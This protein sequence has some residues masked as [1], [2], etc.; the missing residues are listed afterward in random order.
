MDAAS[1]Q[2][3]LLARLRKNADTGCRDWA[4]QV[5]NSGRGPA[6]LGDADSST[7]RA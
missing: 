7:R 2:E 4:G 5:S 3:R 6:M 1:A